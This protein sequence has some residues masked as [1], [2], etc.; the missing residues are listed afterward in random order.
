MTDEENQNFE[1]KTNFKTYDYRNMLVAPRFS[2]G[3]RRRW[4][5]RR[6]TMRIRRQKKK[7][8]RFY[9]MCDLRLPPRCK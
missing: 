3:G 5:R 8:R 1:G 2:V 7:G 9:E 6:R 4:R